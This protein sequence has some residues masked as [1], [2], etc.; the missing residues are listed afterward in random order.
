MEFIVI[1]V[2]ITLFHSSIRTYASFL[3]AFMPEIDLLKS[4][5][6]LHDKPKIQKQPGQGHNVLSL[7]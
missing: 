5:P 1:E 7:Q 6:L 3:Q 2:G 4:Q